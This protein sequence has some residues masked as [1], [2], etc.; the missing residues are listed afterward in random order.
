MFCD[1]FISLNELKKV[2]GSSR[3]GITGCYYV[4]FNCFTADLE[5]FP[6]NFPFS[7]AWREL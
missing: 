6:L 1:E 3:L 5:Y 7:Q 4:A 2:I